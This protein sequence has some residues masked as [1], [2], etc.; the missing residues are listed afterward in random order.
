MTAVEHHNTRP[1]DRPPERWW[2]EF[3]GTVGAVRVRFLWADPYRSTLEQWQGLIDGRGGV[4]ADSHRTARA[5]TSLGSLML[6]NVLTPGQDRGEDADL[7][8]ADFEAQVPREAV[9]GPLAAAIAG[10]A[11]KGWKFAE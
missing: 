7:E 2:L 8:T 4:W 10:A 5:I 11:E 9:A 3:R 1:L 6:F